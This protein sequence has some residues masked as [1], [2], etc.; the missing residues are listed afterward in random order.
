MFQVR[1]L[2]EEYLLSALASLDMPLSPL[3]L[4]EILGVHVQPYAYREVIAEGGLTIDARAVLTPVQLLQL[5]P[6]LMDRGVVPVTRVGIDARARRM[7]FGL[8]R[9][10]QAGENVKQ[11][12]VLVSPVDSGDSFSDV[13]YPPLPFTTQIAHLR[14]T[15]D[16]LVIMLETKGLLSG[17]EMEALWDDVSSRLLDNHYALYRVEDVDAL[18]SQS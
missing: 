8:G 18:S 9:W 6:V 5:K 14:G 11:E 15:L 7:R 17:S 3:P 1:F 16:A 4:L 13:L 2:A 12:L 10:S